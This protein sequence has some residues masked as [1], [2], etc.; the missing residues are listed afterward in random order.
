[1]QPIGLSSTPALY[2]EALAG[3]RATLGDTHPHT[4]TSI[5][6]LGMLL[7]DQG[8]LDEAETLLGEALAGR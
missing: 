3:K 4:L 7:Q 6:N 2:R 5:N 8:K 1:M